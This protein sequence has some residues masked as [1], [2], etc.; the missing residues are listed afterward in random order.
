MEQKN[1]IL[2]VEKENGGLFSNFSD[3]RGDFEAELTHYPN[4]KQKL[5]ETSPHVVIFNVDDAE[6][7]VRT[8]LSECKHSYPNTYWVLSSKNM[9]ANQLVNFMRMGASD[10][11]KQPLDEPDMQNFFKRVEDWEMDQGASQNGASKTHKTYG[12]FACKG[13][14]GVS[15]MAVNMAAMLAKKE[16]IHVALIDY[17]MQHGNVHQMLDLENSFS[18]QELSENFERTDR[19]LL[20]SSLMK[21]KSGISVLGCPKNLEDAEH[22]STTDQKE[23]LKLLKSTFDYTLLDLGHE[24]TNATLSCLD[25]ADTVFLLTTPDLSSL[26]STKAALDTFKQLGYGQD[27]IKLI[28]NRTQI[29]GGIES[30]LIEKNLDYPIHA[31]LSEDPHTSMQAINQGMPLEDIHKKAKLVKELHKLIE[32]LNPKAAAKGG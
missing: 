29:K 30:A 20:E 17:V 12:F 1:P 2:I 24:F 27:K 31:K 4:F 18:L 7:E 26:C 22:L 6:N 19:K 23:V 14:V 11:L 15:L 9:E 5:S 21:H 16:G 13:G 25:F 8:L 32:S 3:K 28:L 10:F